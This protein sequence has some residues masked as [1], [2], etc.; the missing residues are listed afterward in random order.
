MEKSKLI[1][2]DDLPLEETLT[3]HHVVIL[4]KSVFNKNH[5]QYY[6]RTFL[7]KCS[8]ELA[9]Q[10]TTKFFDSAI[11]LRSGKTEVAKEEFYGAKKTTKTIKTIIWDVDV[12]NIVFSKLIE[13]KNNSKYSVGYL[14]Y[15]LRPLVLALPKISGYVRTFKDKNNKLLSFCI[16]DHK[17]LEKYK[18]IWT[19]IEV[20][21]NIELNVLP[22][23]DDRYIK[24]K[25]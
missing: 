7:E 15:V 16:D 9:K 20:L 1:S 19:K 12:G 4:F 22:F 24:T 21:K 10:M 5:N 2:D 18:A 3:L 25:I 23:Y 8:C 13:S 6:Y 17:I 14:D 11:M